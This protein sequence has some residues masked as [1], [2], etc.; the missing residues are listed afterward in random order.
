MIY[1][2]RLD[3]SKFE[4]LDME[5]LCEKYGNTKKL[6]DPRTEIKSNQKSSRINPFLDFQAEGRGRE[7]EVHKNKNALV[8]LRASCLKR[9]NKSSFVLD[10]AYKRRGKH[11]LTNV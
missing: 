4:I 10:D 2:T 7:Q 8:M 9:E 11:N 3:S 5:I 1:R 6:T